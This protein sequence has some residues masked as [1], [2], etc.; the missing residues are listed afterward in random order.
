MIRTHLLSFREINCF[1]VLSKLIKL[2]GKKHQCIVRSAR[3][4]FLKSST[5]PEPTDSVL[6]QSMKRVYEVLNPLVFSSIG[7]FIAQRKAV[8]SKDL[9]GRGQFFFRLPLIQVS[10]QWEPFRL[11][12]TYDITLFIKSEPHGHQ[13]SFARIQLD[14]N[15]RV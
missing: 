6:G 13:N 15:Q 1:G 8:N 2:K 14:Q 7:Q 3:S 12:I 4:F 11:N 5:K 10:G 9:G